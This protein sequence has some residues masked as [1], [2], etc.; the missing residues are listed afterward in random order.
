V[1]HRAHAGRLLGRL[2]GDG[3]GGGSTRIPSAWCGT[4]GFK[5][6]FG[7]TPWVTRPN[8]WGGSTPTLNEGPITRTVE[9]AALVMEALAGYDPR[10]PWSLRERVDWRGAA[11]GSI[12]GMRIA[13]SPDYDV[14]PI[15]PRVAA[16]VADAVR[17][18]ERC[19]A[20]VEEVELG[21]DVD[22]LELG[23]LWCHMIMPA[24]ILALES[25]KRMGYDLL[26]GDSIPPA[27]REWYERCEHVGFRE[28]AADQVMRTTV[29][30]AV[31]RV[32]ASYDLLVSPTLS[33]MPPL[34]GDDGDTMGPSE[35]NGIEIDPSIGFCLT[36]VTNYTG[37]PSASAPAGLADGLP[38][39]LHIVGPM[40]RD[41]VVL[42]ASRAYEQARPWADAYGACRSR[43]L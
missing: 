23:R 28:M 34:N 29:F 26:A 15:D 1:E 14:F 10:D 31:Q 39:G 17:A 40:L 16:T 24:N 35:V 20:T 30:E 2:G 43:P 25:F 38:V 6:S 19:G 21:L 8:A 11:Q 5:A 22:Q 9:D 12:E 13:Y 32:F 3:D 42:A 27:F 7:R 18:F 4:Y 37:H 41:D 33:A 36:Y